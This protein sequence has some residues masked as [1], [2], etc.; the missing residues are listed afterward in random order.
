[1]LAAPIAL[2]RLARLDFAFS[3][4]SYIAKIRDLRLIKPVE[5]T[6]VQ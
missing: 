6:L 1:M 2:C 5:P 4:T 3:L